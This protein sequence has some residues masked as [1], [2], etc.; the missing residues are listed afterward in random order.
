MFPLSPVR[1]CSVSYFLS[2]LDFQLPLKEC[3]PKAYK[4]LEFQKPFKRKHEQETPLLNCRDPPP[5]APLHLPSTV[6]FLE[7]S[8]K[9]QCMYVPS[10]PLALPHRTVLT[11]LVFLK[12]LSLSLFFTSMIF[13]F[14]YFSSYLQAFL[15]ILFFRLI[16]Y[17]KCW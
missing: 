15:S 17:L 16:Y 7:K 13:H 2:L 12:N 6:K 8:I 10:F 14:Y 5:P 11:I 1:V 4:L 9:A 3:F